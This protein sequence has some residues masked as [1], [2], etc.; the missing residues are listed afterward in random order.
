MPAPAAKKRRLGQSLNKTKPA[1][2]KKTK[3]SSCAKAQL[4]RLYTMPTL[5]IRA[6]FPGLLNQQRKIG[7]MLIPRITTASRR[8]AHAFSPSADSCRGATDAA[9]ERRHRCMLS[10]YGVVQFVAARIRQPPSHYQIDE[11][12]RRISMRELTH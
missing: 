3:R 10:L 9:P 1:G 6:A 4:V 5:A 11:L 8:A 12:G 7:L 2:G